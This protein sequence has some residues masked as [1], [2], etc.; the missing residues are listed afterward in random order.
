M[1]SYLLPIADREPLIWILRT[2]RTAF[3]IYRRPEAEG[4][5]KGDVLLLYS[6]RG[7]FHN[8]TRDR[9]RV[10]GIATVKRRVRE[11][12]EPIRFGAREFPIGVDLAFQALAPRNEGVE[13][14]PLVAELPKTFANPAAWS[15]TLRRALVPFDD[16]EA[17]QII[18]ELGNRPATRQVIETYALS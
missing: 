11:L 1:A 17:Q 15:A 13:L 9:G 16:G 14:A 5:T 18:K 3:P 7:C 2:R 10:I 8:P 12:A 4:L 6:T